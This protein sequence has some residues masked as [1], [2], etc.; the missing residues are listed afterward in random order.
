MKALEDENKG[1]TDSIYN[2]ALNAC[3]HCDYKSPKIKEVL[4]NEYFSKK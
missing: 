2:N 1:K 4:E 3:L